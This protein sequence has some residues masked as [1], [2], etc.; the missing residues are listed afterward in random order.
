MIT[1]EDGDTIKTP[2]VRFEKCK[3]VVRSVLGSIDKPAELNSREIY[4][5]SYYFDR[6]ADGGLIEIDKGMLNIKFKLIINSKIAGGVVTVAD[7]FRTAESKCKD[8]NTEQPFLCLDLTFI[9]VLLTD[10]FGLAMTT[11]IHVSPSIK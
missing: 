7:F 9:S 8:P 2:V 1:V 5:F 3:Q 10:G 4:A 11:P 6:A